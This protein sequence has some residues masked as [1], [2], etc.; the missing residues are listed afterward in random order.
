MTGGGTSIIGAQNIILWG[1]VLSIFGRGWGGI[2]GGESFLWEVWGRGKEM[3]VCV[4]KA[5]VV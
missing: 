5:R 4:S 1:Q 2:I 3:C